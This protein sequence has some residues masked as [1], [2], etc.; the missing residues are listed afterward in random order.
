MS[1]KEK[2]IGTL[3]VLATLL[4]FVYGFYQT[5]QSNLQ[6]D[7][8]TKMG[9]VTGYNSG[10]SANTSEILLEKDIVGW[11]KSAGRNDCGSSEALHRATILQRD[12]ARALA[13]LSAEDFNNFLP[14][15]KNRSRL[16]NLIILITGT[17]TFTILVIT[18]ILATR[19][20]RAGT[21]Q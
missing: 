2:I 18:L 15:Y 5:K 1:K 6:S 14:E 7:F 21:T 19:K 16:N 4:A 20:Q 11:C 12:S 10:L 13:S 9:Y 8:L 3:T 17:L